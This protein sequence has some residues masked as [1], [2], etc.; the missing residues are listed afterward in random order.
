[1]LPGPPVAGPVRRTE[2]LSPASSANRDPFLPASAPSGQLKRMP[3]LASPPPD[4]SASPVRSTT[5][6]SGSEP[7]GPEIPEF[8]RPPRPALAR[9]VRD[10][11]TPW[12]DTVGSAAHIAT[13]TAATAASADTTTAILF[14]LFHR[15]TTR[16]TAS[17]ATRPAVAIRTIRRALIPVSCPDYPQGISRCKVALQVA[18]SH[19]CLSVNVLRHS[20]PCSR[21]LPSP[22]PGR[23]CQG[24]LRVYVHPAARR[25]RLPGG[26]RRT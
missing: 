6:L 7:A 16:S 21:S 5:A 24:R 10:I 17:T 3:V 14:A 23:F 2:A 18:V 4:A 26:H 25:L 19:C 22:W 11:R 20:C 15:N 8:A 12:P 13:P 1:M 9:P